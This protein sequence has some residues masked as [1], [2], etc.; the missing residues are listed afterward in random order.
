MVDVQSYEV[1]TEAIEPKNGLFVA[2]E[3][4]DGSG[5]SLLVENLKTFFEDRKN[6]PTVFLEEPTLF[7]K[8]EIMADHGEELSAKLD[9][10]L[11]AT[12]RLRQ[13][14]EITRKALREGKLVVTDRSVVSSLAYQEAR[15]VSPEWLEAV[16]RYVKSPDLVILLDLSPVK[17]AERV[18]DRRKAAD[19]E[20]AVNKRK[21]QHRVRENYLELA[22]RHRTTF[23]ILRSD[24]LSAEN[25]ARTAG[26]TILGRFREHQGEFESNEK[27]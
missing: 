3:G 7:L 8:E 22:K 13:Y 16:N 11:F 1:A 15:G 4:I 6:P 23:H 27:K 19:F 21:F 20:D 2:V 24:Y 17:A 5:K 25:L 10:L 9:A 18:A 14:D 12:D 26:E